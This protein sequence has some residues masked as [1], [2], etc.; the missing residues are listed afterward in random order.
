MIKIDSLVKYGVYYLTVLHV[1]NRRMM[2]S[3]QAV[4]ECQQASTQ[5]N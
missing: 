1:D 5:P 3:V 4:E 2:G